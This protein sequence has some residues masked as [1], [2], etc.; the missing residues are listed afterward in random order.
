MTLY[1][2]K[3]DM[4]IT[5]KRR[6]SYITSILWRVAERHKIVYE[7]VKT[8]TKITKKSTTRC[9]STKIYRLYIFH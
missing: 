4:Y 5:H 8:K 3:N 7:K 6:L 2:Y 9:V 1:L